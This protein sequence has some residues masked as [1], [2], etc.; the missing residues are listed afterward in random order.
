MKI[1]CKDN[2]NFEFKNDKKFE[3]KNVQN[4]KTMT[5][6]LFGLIKNNISLQ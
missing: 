6:L 2:Q 4:E 1:E 3:Y 5:Y